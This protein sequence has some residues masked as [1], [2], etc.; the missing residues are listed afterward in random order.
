M[1]VLR[2]AITVGI[3]TVGAA[4]GLYFAIAFVTQYRVDE[5]YKAWALI[6]DARGLVTRSRVLMAGI[7]AWKATRPGS[8]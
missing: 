1:R 5:G 3:L 2:S 4:V 8:T 6:D 7:P